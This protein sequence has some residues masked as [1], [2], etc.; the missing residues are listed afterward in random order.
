M[1]AHW[2]HSKAATAAPVVLSVAVALT[3]YATQ[4]LFTSCGRGVAR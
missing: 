3:F 1:K 4:M 2:F